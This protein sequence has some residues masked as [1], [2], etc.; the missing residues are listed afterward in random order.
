MMTAPSVSAPPHAG[1]SAVAVAV[2]ADGAGRGDLD[3]TVGSSLSSSSFFSVYVVGL[4]AVL[5]VATGVVWSLLTLPSS[6]NRIVRG[7][8]SSVEHVVG[9]GSSGRN[10]APNTTTIDVDVEAARTVSNKAGSADTNPLSPRNMMLINA[11][12][13]SEIMLATEQ[14]LSAWLPRALPRD[15]HMSVLVDVV[16]LPG[17]ARADD[18]RN[19]SNRRQRDVSVDVASAWFRHAVR[20]RTR[21]ITWPSVGATDSFAGVVTILSSPTTTDESITAADPFLSAALSSTAADDGGPNRSAVMGCSGGVF[22]KHVRGC[23]GEDVERAF[24]RFSRF[25]HRL[26]ND[27]EFDGWIR[28][29]AGAHSFNVHVDGPE[30]GLGATRFYRPSMSLRTAADGAGGAEGAGEGESPSTPSTCVYIS[31]FEVFSPG[32]YTLTVQHHLDG[33]WALEEFHATAPPAMGVSLVPL[34]LRQSH[35]ENGLSPGLVPA[36]QQ[37]TFR[38]ERPRRMGEGE[39]DSVAGLDG[40]WVKAPQPSWRDRL[41]AELE[42]SAKV[43][44]V[45]VEAVPQSAAATE[46]RPSYFPWKGWE[47][48]FESMSV[49]AVSRNGAAAAAA[50]SAASFPTPEPVIPFRVSFFPHQLR[51]CGMWERSAGESASKNVA[52]WRRRRPPMKIHFQGDSHIRSLF[53]HFYSA[54][55]NRAAPVTRG[56]QMTGNISSRRR[57]AGREPSSSTSGG[58]NDAHS[59]PAASFVASFVW[60]SVLDSFVRRGRTDVIHA[61]ARLDEAGKV[62]RS[63]RCDDFFLAPSD[64]DLLVYDAFVLG[65]GSWPSNCRWSAREMREHFRDIARIVYNLT[66]MH[67][68]KVVWVGCPAPPVFF[69]KSRD[70]R[71]TA[72]RL[73]LYAHMGRKFMT[74]AGADVLD[75]FMLTRVQTSLQ[76][77]DGLHYDWSAIPYALVDELANRLCWRG[78]VN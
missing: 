10:L 69:R 39:R 40:R 60:D 48:V 63:T 12:N 32:T 55:D 25:T 6:A 27:A 72:Y 53:H 50:P 19:D 54:A 41:T 31:A 68:K 15:L 8:R 35:S 47:W 22:I 65:I 30:K 62:Q 26:T 75:Y 23:A 59:S 14:P 77:G 13:L 78:G 2:G 28:E 52:T 33:Y 1:G 49:S 71:L 11:A 44:P 4:V 73:G 42:S 74:L 34:V 56:L 21:S 5:T 9:G 24:K 51:N 17:E 43:Q 76:R 61:G 16:L 20:R 37:L 7:G 18:G 38:C 58:E 46:E 67:K 45:V 66:H 29:T 57:S 70:F 3:V 64:N 36:Q